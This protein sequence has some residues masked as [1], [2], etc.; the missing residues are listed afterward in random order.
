MSSLANFV[1]QPPSPPP[2]DLG[3][4]R[5][6]A[7]F[8]PQPCSRSGAML[9]TSWCCAV[10]GTPCPSPGSVL[11]LGAL[12]GAGCSLWGC[13][14]G[15]GGCLQ[16]VTGA[17]PIWGS[18][19]GARGCSSSARLG[20]SL[21]ASLQKSLGTL[22]KWKALPTGCAG[23]VQS[24][25][26]AECLGGGG[27][28]MCL[29]LQHPRP[30][31]LFLSASGTQPCSLSCPVHADGAGSSTER[32]LEADPKHLAAALGAFCGPS[33]V[34]ALPSARDNKNPGSF[35]RGRVA[36]QIPQGKL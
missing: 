31:S 22:A 10:V 23:L 14:G 26:T 13:W 36:L 20:Q 27:W 21:L 24:L 18:G 35:W 1:V 29:G 11:L 5:S 19:Q 2:G 30:L 9:V 12:V 34:P 3:V 4:F 32:V 28:Q 7:S 16:E 25:P 15:P 17:D 6:A 33:L 8:Q